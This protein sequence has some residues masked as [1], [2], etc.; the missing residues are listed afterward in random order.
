MTAIYSQ[1]AYGKPTNNYEQF[2]NA[3]VVDERRC[4]LLL[5]LQQVKKLA[6]TAWKAADHGKVEVV[7]SDVLSSSANDSECVAK[8]CVVRSSSKIPV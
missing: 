4:S 8:I 6:D 2:V 1:K 7:V 5:P 3:F